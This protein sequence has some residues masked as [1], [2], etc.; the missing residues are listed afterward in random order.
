MSRARLPSARFE[1][2]HA[3]RA[4]AL[5]GLCAAKDGASQQ[6]SSLPEPPPRRI[7][8][9]VGG[10]SIGRQRELLKRYKARSAAD[11][12]KAGAAGQ[13]KRINNASLAS[14]EREEAP[15]PPL[16]RRSRPAPFV[17]SSTEALHV[18]LTLSPSAFIPASGSLRV[19]SLWRVAG[20]RH[21]RRQRA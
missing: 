10:L 19:P 11:A 12:T 7:T 2:W 13:R 15:A 16:V 18:S 1:A 21:K 9:R 8:G 4:C 20:F 17:Q 6:P 3:M 5:R 14:Q